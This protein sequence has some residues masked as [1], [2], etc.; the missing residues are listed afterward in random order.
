MHERSVLLLAVKT[1]KQP[2]K[3]IGQDRFATLEPCPAFP[4]APALKRLTQGIN[5]FQSFGRF[6]NK[7]FVQSTLFFRGHF[8]NLG[9]SATAARMASK[10]S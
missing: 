6:R 2:F 4:L 8:G 10:S 9:M 3:V 1:W 7:P 5:V